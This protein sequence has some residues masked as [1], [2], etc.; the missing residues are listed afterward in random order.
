M[1]D[2]GRGREKLKCGEKETGERETRNQRWRRLG[3]TR[4]LFGQTDRQDLKYHAASLGPSVFEGRKS[5]AR[6]S[7]NRSPLSGAC[8]APEFA[9]RE[10]GWNLGVGF[11][12]KS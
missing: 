4:P 2:P 3:L 10:R 11:R 6:G 1:M 12:G 8:K 7:G 5:W 9:N